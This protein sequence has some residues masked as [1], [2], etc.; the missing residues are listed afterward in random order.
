MTD[1]N[2]A[3][4]LTDKQRR[5]YLIQMVNDIRLDFGDGKGTL[6]EVADRMGK[7][8]DAIVEKEKCQH[9]CQYYAPQNQC[10]DCRSLTT[11]GKGMRP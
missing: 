8:L 5:I 6:G 7:E 10:P 4:R 1:E 3:P 2:D 9:G 11:P